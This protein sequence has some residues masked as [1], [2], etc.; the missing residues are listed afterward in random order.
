MTP[1]IFYILHNTYFP[2]IFINRIK[3][4]QYSNLIIDALFK[5]YKIVSCLSFTKAASKL[6]GNLASKCIISLVVG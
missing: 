2:L 6:S 5:Y 1:I 3:K 4:H